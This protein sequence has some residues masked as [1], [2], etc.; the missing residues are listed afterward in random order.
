MKRL[1]I[2]PVDLYPASGRDLFLHIQ[3]PLIPELPHEK[4]KGKPAGV[5]EVYDGQPACWVLR[6]IKQEVLKV[7]IA[8]AKPEALGDEIGRGQGR[9][10]FL[11]EMTLADMFNQFH[12]A[13]RPSDI[14][15]T[16]ERPRD[17]G[18]T[19]SFSWLS[20]SSRSRRLSKSRG[21]S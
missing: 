18:H 10:E 16:A 2:I 13:I 5:L 17:T 4:T 19:F 8:I 20:H 15:K 7:E 9:V 11:L 1:N 6:I 14:R 3:F 21:A 12:R